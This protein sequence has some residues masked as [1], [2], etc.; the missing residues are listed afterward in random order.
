MV[1]ALNENPRIVLAYP[2]FVRITPEGEV[3]KKPTRY[4]STE[5]MSDFGRVKAV[6]CEARAFGKMVYGLFRADALRR[7]GVFP[8]ILFPDV[9]LLQELA[10]LGDF[11]QVEKPLWS[12]RRVA[13][14]SIGRQKESLFIKKVW[15]LYLPWPLVNSVTIFRD[16][17]LT[18]DPRSFKQRCLGLYIAF[19]YF[20]RH[21]GKLGAGSWIGSY[22]EW[23]RGKKPWIKRLKRRILRSRQDRA[24]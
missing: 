9:V 15:Y 16:T 4:F 22:Y 17:V 14:F 24:G 23:T 13:D 8:R 7:A 5:D 20:C 19:T 12:V 21:I 2:F 3:I 10:L 11:K 1:R 6:C 18:G